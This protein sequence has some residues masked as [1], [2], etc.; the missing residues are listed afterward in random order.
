[1]LRALNVCFLELFLDQLPFN[2]S[3]FCVR[4]GRREQLGMCQMVLVVI[5]FVVPLRCAMVLRRFSRD[6][7]EFMFRIHD[8]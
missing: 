7:E 3:C 8:R 4:E 1:M 6:G 5:E 2:Q